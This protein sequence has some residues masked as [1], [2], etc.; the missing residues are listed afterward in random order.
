M[1]TTLPLDKM[2][3]SEKLSALEDIWENLSRAQDAIPSPEWHA[4]VLIAREQKIQEGKAKFLD[5][6][7]A[8][9][10]IWDQIK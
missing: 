2:T 7:D 8:K 4:D 1:Q 3:I 10:R 9:R 6:D 5:L